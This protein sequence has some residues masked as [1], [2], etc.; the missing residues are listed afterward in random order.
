MLH[1]VIRIFVAERKS[2]AQHLAA[3]PDHVEPNDLGLVTGIICVGWKF[4]G[5]LGWHNPGAV[6]LPNPLRLHT[7]GA[8]VGFAAVHTELEHLHGIAQVGPLKLRVHRVS[9]LRAAPVT[10][11]R[12]CD[13]AARWLGVI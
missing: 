7:N 10:Q 12:Y 3:V 1:H 6:S 2:H 4:Q 9:R 5:V 11:P 13:S 8:W